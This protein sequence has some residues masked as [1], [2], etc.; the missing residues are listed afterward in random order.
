MNVPKAP[1]FLT[2]HT[3]IREFAK[4]YYDEV[5]MLSKSPIFHVDHT[6]YRESKV[7]NQYER[8]MLGILHN[9]ETTS[10]ADILSEQKNECI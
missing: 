5:L 8:G 6:K 2:D 10:R 1:T 9:I 4:E 3:A 7:N